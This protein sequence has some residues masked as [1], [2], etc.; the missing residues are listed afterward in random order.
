MPTALA[1]PEPSATPAGVTPTPS[2]TPD[3]SAAPSDPS[4]TVSP[5][6]ANDPDDGVAT[7]PSL[8]EPSAEPGSEV[9]TAPMTLTSWGTTDSAFEAAAVIDGVVDEG[10]CTM[11]LTRRDVTR[12]VSGPSARSATSSSC[13]QGLSIPL[14]DLTSG[15]WSLAVRF[16][17]DSITGV[18]ATQ[19][20][21]VP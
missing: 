15:G 7:D 10:T 19:E 5:E 1:T 6:P 4:A 17:S 16:A 9:A 11:T 2:A 18:T 8:P 13:A 21:R 14:E 20:V 12:A 3:T